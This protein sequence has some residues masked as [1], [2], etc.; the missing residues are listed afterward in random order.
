MGEKGRGP[1][2]KGLWAYAYDVTLPDREDRL[3]SIQG[4]LDR[5]HKEA[6]DGAR[7]WAGRVVVEPEIM[8]ILVVSDSPAQDRDVNVRLEAE[9]KTLE[10]EFVITVPLAVVDDVASRSNNGGRARG[11]S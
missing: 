2:P 8:R 6:K 1:P 3:S 10:A 7:T 9:L 4:L 11:A 5:E